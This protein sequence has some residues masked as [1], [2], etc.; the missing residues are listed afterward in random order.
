MQFKC[1]NPDCEKY[2]AVRNINWFDGGHIVEC[3]HCN[4]VHELRQIPTPQDAPIQFEIVGL[5]EL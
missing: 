1:R 2:S 5:L 3:E 4:S